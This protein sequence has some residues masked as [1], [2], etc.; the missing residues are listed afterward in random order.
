DAGLLYG[1][2]FP[3]LISVAVTPGVADA[4]ASAGARASAAISALST[5]LL[6]MMSSCRAPG[7]SAGSGPILLRGNG[8]ARAAVPRRPR[9]ARARRTAPA[10]PN[11]MTYMK[12]IRKTP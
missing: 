6:S 3:N 11:G 12:P 4:I 8:Q 9:R 1:L 5:V 10:I 2:G 7:G